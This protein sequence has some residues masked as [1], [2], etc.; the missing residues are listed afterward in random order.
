[1]LKY[2]TTTH[3]QIASIFSKKISKNAEKS[4]ENQEVFPH[5]STFQNFRFRLCSKEGSRR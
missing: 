4:P 1:M 2:N 5:F 3:N